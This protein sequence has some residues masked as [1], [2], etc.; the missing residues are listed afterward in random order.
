MKTLVYSILLPASG[1]ADLRKKMSLEISETLKR[2]PDSE[3]NNRF[4]T[5]VPSAGVGDSIVKH[6][7]N[8]LSY[9]HRQDE[10]EEEDEFLYVTCLMH[11]SVVVL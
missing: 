10:K 3:K 5:A 9:G 8:N 7:Q 2:C 1:S 4:W 6:L 11:G